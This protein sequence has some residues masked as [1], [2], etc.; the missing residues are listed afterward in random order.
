MEINNPE[1]E[2]L[3][4]GENKPKTSNKN[5]GFVFCFFHPQMQ[6]EPTDGVDP[7]IRSD[8]ELLLI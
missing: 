2:I 7:S 8:E 4:D 6:S 5:G 3:G 1:I